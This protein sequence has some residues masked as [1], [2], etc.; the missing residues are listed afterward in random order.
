[1][2]VS[3]IA[4]ISISNVEMMD[5]QC[6]SKMDEMSSSD[7]TSIKTEPISDASYHQYVPNSGTT[8]ETKQETVTTAVGSKDYSSPVSGYN[9]ACTYGELGHDNC[10]I[11]MSV[12]E[13]YIDLHVAT[14]SEL[15]IKQ[16]QGNVTPDDPYN[17]DNVHPTSLDIKPDNIPMSVKEEYIDLMSVK[18]EY[19]DSDVVTASK[20][21]IKQ[22]QGNMASDD[23]YNIDNCYPKRV[24]LDIKPDN[25]SSDVASDDNCSILMSVKD[26]Y[27]DSDV[28]TG[29]R[30]TIKQEQGNITPDDPYNIKLKTHLM[31]HAGDK[32]YACLQ[33][34]KRF[35]QARNLKTHMMTSHTGH[36][37]RRMMAHTG[38]KPYSCSHCHKRYIRRSSLKIHLMIHTGE[39]PYFCCHCDKRFNQRSSLKMHLMIHMKNHILVVTVIRDLIKE[40]VSRCI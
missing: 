40:A 13:E 9:R 4:D 5:V 30:L 36:L 37:Q 25:V 26:E 20:L 38:D 8:V 31:T 3:V 23:P 10:S 33:C 12:K 11:M 27:A 35:I 22:E 32:P 2:Y 17:I 24:T 39:E 7:R 29:S 16:E 6:N 21:N 34:D 18:E 28:A 19:I 15:K 14:A 1:M